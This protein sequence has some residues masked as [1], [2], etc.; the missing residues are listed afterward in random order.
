MANVIRY[1]SDTL[2]R[3]RGTIDAGGST[4]ITVASGGSGSAKL[5]D[6][7]KDTT[8]SAAEATSQTVLSVS[9]TRG[10]G[11]GFQVGD[12][13]YIELDDGTYDTSDIVSIQHADKTITITTG[14]TSAA[15]AG[16]HIAV[17]LGASITLSEYGTPVVP[18]VPNADWG[19]RGTIADTH[20]D[21]EV[22]MAVRI[23]IELSGGAGLQSRRRITATVEGYA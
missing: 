18:Y 23:Q 5:F 14:L 8:L 10:N 16:A 9:A 17:L 6:D 13:L 4:A 2:V 11:H 3:Y 15:A 12:A 19:W 1:K 21:L 20:G 7:N 22:G